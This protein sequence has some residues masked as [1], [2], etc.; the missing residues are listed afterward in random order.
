[1][2]RRE[3]SRGQK[4]LVVTVVLGTVVIAVIGFV[5][6]YTAVLR[7]AQRNRFGWFSYLLPIGIDVGIT[8]FLAL[9][10]L[11]T[12]MRIP[13]PI[14]RQLAWVLTGATIVF[15]A[16]SAWPNPLSS[17]MHAVVPLLFVAAIEAARHTVGRLA[18]IEAN[19][20]FE[21]TRL[22]RWI[23]APIATL[24]LFRRRMLWELRSYEEALEM[25]RRRLVYRAR[26]RAAFGR[27]W[28]YRAPVDYLLLLKLANLGEQLPEF[29]LESAPDL[30]V[31]TFSIPNPT[32]V[33]AAIPAP[34]EEPSTVQH[35]GDL[36][37]APEDGSELSALAE[38]AEQ[39]TGT[40]VG[41]A[42]PVAPV[43][44]ATRTRPAAAEE[45]EARARVEGR[46]RTQESE[47]APVPNQRETRKAISRQGSAVDRYRA[48]FVDYT[49]Q[50]GT[51]P[52]GD[53]LAKWLFEQHGVGGRTGEA[54]SSGHLRRYLPGFKE[55]WDA[56]H[57]ARSLPLNDSQ[58]SAP[59]RP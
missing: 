24:R 9:D 37:V 19:Q 18:Q 34:R 14:L 8:V 30:P 2:D 38:L 46:P 42:E 16:A 4:A 55:A 11:L 36:V 6:S 15:N 3:V 1:M 32:G 51:F 41:V 13:L 23:W 59:G 25:E 40:V 53:Q 28:R 21:N 35:S 29:K 27:L 26:L 58:D 39:G 43:D 45:G 48:A 57:T 44:E 54:L 52:D 49:E 5:G 10:L 22:G 17:G 56:E 33:L 31:P 50:H 20:L 12:W 7:L 47:P